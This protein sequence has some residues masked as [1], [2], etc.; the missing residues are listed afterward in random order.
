[1]HKHTFFLSKNSNFAQHLCRPSCRFWLFTQSI[2][3]L[4]Y[5]CWHS[6]C[7]ENRDTHVYLI[8]W[9]KTFF[10]Y[11]IWILFY[12]PK[13]KLFRL[14]NQQKIL[15][16]N[17]KKIILPSTIKNETV[18]IV[19]TYKYLRVTMD[20]LIGQHYVL[21]EGLHNKIN[22]IMFFLRNLYSF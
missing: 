3:M 16:K 5:S 19:K 2:F 6:K 22:Q 7:Q 13:H 20:D 14:K 11:K 12:C 4:K 18:E 15:S 21:N 1:M 8:K 9:N 17:L 10:K